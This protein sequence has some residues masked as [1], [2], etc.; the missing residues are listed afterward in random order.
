MVDFPLVVPLPGK[1]SPL[2]AMLL[3]VALLA[4]TAPVGHGSPGRPGEQGAWRPHMAAAR[5]Y[6]ERRRGDVAF[7]VIDERGR[8]YGFRPA[9]TAPAASVFKVMLLVTY[10]R[11]R[12]DEALSRGDRALLGPMIRR[13]DSVAAT[14]VRDLLGRRRIER[15]ARV[16]GMRDFRY[17]AVWGESRTSPR[18]QVR[19]MRRFRTFVPGRHWPYARF[20][21]SHVVG[22]QRWGVGRVPHPG[23]A[24]YFKGGWG[25]GSGRVDHQ[26]A[27]LERGG[28][29]IAV[30]VFTQ[31]DPDHRYGKRTLRGVFA[32][33]L[34]G[35]P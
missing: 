28:Q 11:R 2:A 6:A 31:F 17:A 20:L 30:A 4:T 5:R 14:R 32:R 34:R 26:V 33:V 23:W 10:L 1:T 18:D 24:L 8:S 21:L 15:L 19:F 13:S 3:V 12:H 16:A 29:R 7:A 9:R 35:L 25:S 27:L 22:P